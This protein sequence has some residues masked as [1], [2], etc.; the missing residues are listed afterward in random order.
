[1]PVFTATYTYPS[2]VEFLLN[3]YSSIISCGM[4]AAVRHR[5]SL[6]SIGVWC[7]CV[8]WSCAPDWDG[9]DRGGLGG[10]LCP[11]FFD[12]S[13]CTVVEGGAGVEGSL[14][15]AVCLLCEGFACV[16]CTGRLST[17]DVCFVVSC[18]IGGL[19][20]VFDFSGGCSM[21]KC[22]AI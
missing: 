17:G 20:K 9:E 16:F 12:C 2:C 6:L 13:S 14:G 19:K 5:Y 21:P 18:S 1:M 22:I 10:G 8:W 7:F 3:L 4:S 11:R 15:G